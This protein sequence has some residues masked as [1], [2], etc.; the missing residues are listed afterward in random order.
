MSF[1]RIA[2]GLQLRSRFGAAFGVRGGSYVR[3]GENLYATGEESLLTEYVENPVFE[4]AENVLYEN[5]G[6]EVELLDLN[7]IEINT[8]ETTELL[9]GTAETSFGATASAA[10]VSTAV[11][12]AAAPSGSAVAAGVGVGIFVTSVGLGIGLSGGA[13]LPGHHNIGPGNEPNPE[14]VDQDDQIAFDH[15]IRYGA[16]ET[17]EDV[18]EAD[19]IA[20]DEFDQDW[21]DNSN[22]HSLAGRTGIQIK[23]AV[24]QYTGVLYP[25]NLPSTGKPT[26]WVA[27]DGVG[28][29]IIGLI[30]VLIGLPCLGLKKHIQSLNT[31]NKDQTK[32]L[33][34]YLILSI[35]IK[36][37]LAILSIVMTTESKL[38]LLLLLVVLVIN[39][40]QTLVLAQLYVVKAQLSMLFETLKNK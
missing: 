33:M 5:L 35:V 26:T 37:M 19:S 6:G 9:S 3:I 15:D 34:L 36:I 11:G 12:A 31:I 30:S 16:A 2:E 18:R 25:P 7:E 21:Q 20:I 28:I 39:P 32:E 8:S 23:K 24:E 27:I 13:T 1:V 29:S 10:G 22:F 40:Y 17:Q 38:S 4:T 14:G